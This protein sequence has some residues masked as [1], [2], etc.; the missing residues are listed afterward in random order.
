SD[1]VEAPTTGSDAGITA[2]VE[3]TASGL[4]ESRGW[5]IYRAYQARLRETNSLDFDDLVARARRELVAHPPL[6]HRWRMRSAMLLVD[7]VQDLDR[8][9]LQ[10]ALLLA[11]PAAN[12]FLVGDDDQ[13]IYAWRLADVR[14]VLGLAAE[15]PGLRRVDL[16][17][18]YRCP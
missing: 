18:N 6:L 15:L 12:I 7:E 8:S 5:S 10:L 16:I 2:D 1:A 11:G 3:I 13:T 14:R 9:Q 17:T 4:A